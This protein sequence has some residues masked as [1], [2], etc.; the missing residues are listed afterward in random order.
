ML[1]RLLLANSK[2]I[3]FAVHC[4]CD[5]ASRLSCAIHA[6]NKHPSAACL[7]FSEIYLI[8]CF[9]FYFNCEYL[10]GGIA[11]FCNWLNVRMSIMLFIF[12]KYIIFIYYSIIH[13]WQNWKISWSNDIASVGIITVYREQRL[14]VMK[15][16]AREEEQKSTIISLS[17]NVNKNQDF[18]FFIFLLCDL[19]LN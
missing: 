2:L 15:K 16:R 8:F 6:L 1:L 17:D 10:F 9:S 3:V 4:W 5:F 13:A 14:F 11:K 19:T 18:R 7:R 12:S